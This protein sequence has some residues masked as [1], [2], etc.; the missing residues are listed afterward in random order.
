MVD[1]DGDTDLTDFL[2]SLV[3]LADVNAER[4]NAQT[5]KAVLRELADRTDI[6]LG[7]WRGPKGDLRLVAIKAYSVARDWAY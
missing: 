3:E 4:F 7:L 1:N 6:I 2:G 5:D